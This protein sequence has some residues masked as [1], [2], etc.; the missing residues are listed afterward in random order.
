MDININRILPISNYTFDSEI[1]IL[2]EERLKF[3]NSNPEI[4]DFTISIREVSRDE[5]NIN[6]LVII[7]HN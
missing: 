3:I 6:F 5:T 7:S 4:T 2:D 1:D